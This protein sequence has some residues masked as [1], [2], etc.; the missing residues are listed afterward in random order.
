MRI[1]RFWAPPDEPIHRTTRK[2]WVGRNK[3][4]WYLV[5]LC[6]KKPAWSRSKGFR[7]RGVLQE[8][9]CAINFEAITGFNLKP[10]QG[11]VEVEIT[12]KRVAKRKRR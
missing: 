5:G 4:G 1:F 7:T 6:S 11:P 2:V 3:N 9:F 10:G 12:A 8:S